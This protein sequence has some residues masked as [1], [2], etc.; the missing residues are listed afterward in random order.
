MYLTR[1]FLEPTS[2]LV[3]A[4]AANPDGLHK[5]VMRMFPKDSGPEA[6][7]THAVLYR[8]DESSDGRLMLLVQ[9]RPK[10][11]AS[12]LAQEYLL[13]PARD[14]WLLELGVLENPAVHAVGDERAAIE[15]G[16][17]FHFRLRGNT[18]KKIRTKSE[19]GGARKNGKRVELR[20]DE[21]R[22]R[23]L[24]RHAEASGFA[25]SALRV[26]EVKSRGNQIRVAGA[27]FEGTLEVTDPAAFRKALEDGVGP[28][29]AYGFGLLSIRP[30]T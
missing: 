30:A 13:D 24:R 7:K 20:G 14:A 12:L 10:P 2:R 6:R 21:A 9:S 15:V 3:R 5:T 16:A 18:T 4:D 28:A 19:P 17:R 11:D 26:T 25:F 23:W 8:L 1:L 27:L 22:L 29:K